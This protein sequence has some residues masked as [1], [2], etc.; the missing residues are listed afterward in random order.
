MRLFVVIGLGQFGRH[1][2]TTLYAGGADVIA[3]DQDEARVEM[4]KEE[5]GQAICLDATDLD[6]L[7]SIG[8]GKADT[9]IVALGEDDLEASI[10]CC[11]AISDLGIGQ[12][13][14]RSASE[15]HGRILSRVGASR[16]IYPEKQMGEQL[17]KSLLTSGVLDQ[18]TLSTGQ[19]VANIR[20][21]HDL[22]GKTIK[23]CNLQDRYSLAVIGIQ[24]PKRSVDDRGELHEELILIPV[25]DQD[26][27]IGEDDILIVVGNQNQIDLISRK[28]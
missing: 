2:A 9:V 12:I 6:A 14:V 25:P 22:V 28:E 10:I 5:V 24:Q 18:V 13:I 1:T 3:I 20:P 26:S 23:E 8:T 17:A 16:V 15:E 27:V 19:T 7:R 4:I 11:T 21:R